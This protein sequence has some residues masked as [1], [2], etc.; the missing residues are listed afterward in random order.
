MKIELTP[1]LEQIIQQQVDSGHYKSVDEVI[2]AGVKLLDQLEKTYQGRYEEIRQEVLQGIEASN[3]GE[4]IDSKVVFQN[5]QAK[6]NDKK[7]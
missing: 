4:V 1:E 6:L 3:R 5:L 2:Y 7:V